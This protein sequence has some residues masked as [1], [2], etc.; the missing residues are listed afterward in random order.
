MENALI[1]KFI[2]IGL[3]VLAIIVSGVTYNRQRKLHKYTATNDFNSKWQTFNQS[4]LADPVFIE[5]ERNL[6]PFGKLSENEIKKL[7]F[8]FMRWNVVYSAF[9]SGDL[10]KGLA[11]SSLNNEA[12]ISFHD[13]KFIYDHVFGRG[14]DRNFTKM[15]EEK[16]KEI[17]KNGETLPME[18]D[19][20]KSFVVK[21]NN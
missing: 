13:R 6:H 19:N 11:Q 10:S 16:W 1:L 14:Y 5:F 15:F 3:S 7:Y 4:L 12:N 18:G 8:Y 21:M 20:E 17:E 9:Q 2:S